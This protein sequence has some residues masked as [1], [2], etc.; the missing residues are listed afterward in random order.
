M[1]PLAWDTAKPTTTLGTV[2]RY[3]TTG[4]HEI[5]SL[6]PGPGSWNRAVSVSKPN[7]FDD[8]GIGFK[9]IPKS[10]LF[11]ATLESGL[12]RFQSR[13]VFRYFGIWLQPIPK[14]KRFSVLRKRR[15]PIPKSK[16]LSA[17]W[18]QL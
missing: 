7:L 13:N 10:K 1:Q 4:V 17:L 5:S 6:V 12:S 2:L 8:S 14:S 16:R 18:N 15:K 11:F 3:G 9:L